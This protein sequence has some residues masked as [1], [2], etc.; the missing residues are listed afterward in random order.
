MIEKIKNIKTITYLGRLNKI[1]NIN[2]QID[3][4]YKLIKKKH[5]YV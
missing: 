4:I 1:K 2:L 3:L 5:K